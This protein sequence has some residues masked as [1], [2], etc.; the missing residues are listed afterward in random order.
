MKKNLARKIY[1]EK[2]RSLERELF[3][4]LEKETI[5]R[6]IQLI[7]QLNP[8][9]VHCYLPINNKQ[10]IDTELIFQYCWDNN[11][12]TV[13]P[14]SDLKNSTM[15]SVSYNNKSQLFSNKYGIPEPVK[16]V[17]NENND[18]ELIITPL[19]A[20]DKTGNRVGFGKGFYDRFFSKCNMKNK[21]VGLSLF[22]PI[23]EIEDINKHDVSLDYV[24]NPGKIFTF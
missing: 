24:V 10:E 15:I 14:V 8:K 13:V 17:I 4:K 7:K 1:L 9:V 16:P 6:C 22:E 5:Y 19:I 3:N 23:D 11:I 12:E 18:I 2:R 20:F 21:K